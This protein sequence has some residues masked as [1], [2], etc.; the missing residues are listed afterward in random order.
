MQTYR[1]IPTFT[2]FAEARALRTSPKAKVLEN[3]VDTTSLTQLENKVEHLEELTQ[4]IIVDLHVQTTTLSASMS[5]LF[6]QLEK[7]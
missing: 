2:K 4:L 7:L 3:K 6:Q 5:T 1:E